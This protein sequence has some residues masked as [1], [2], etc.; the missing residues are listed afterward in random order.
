MMINAKRTDLMSMLSN[1]MKVDNLKGHKIAYAVARNKR[2]LTEERDI[3][4]E[5]M[6]SSKKFGEFTKKRVDLCK[7]LATKDDNGNPVIV[8]KNYVGLDDNPD[9]I[10]AIE[11]LQEEYKDAIEKDENKMLD[12]QNA[13]DEE[14]EFN[15]FVISYDDI[16]DDVT[17][18]QMD[19]LFLMIRDH[20]GLIEKYTPWKN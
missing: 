15:M 20:E 3:L 4:N 9:F 7:K 14:I 2:A 6:I 1:L 11:S 18:G 13:M 16:P 17:V 8:D 19:V 5:I 12:Y 10:K